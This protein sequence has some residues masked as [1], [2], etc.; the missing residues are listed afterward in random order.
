ML[1]P[2]VAIRFQF[3]RLTLALA[4]IASV[5]LLGTAE[6]QDDTFKS[7]P[8][9][10]QYVEKEIP[11]DLETSEKRAI[12]V[13]NSNAKKLR[14]ADKKAAQASLEGS[15]SESTI[16]PYLDGLILSEMTQTGNETLSELGSLRISFIKD[17]V[18]DTPSGN[19]EQL[20]NT[21]IIPFADKVIADNYHPAV[22]L[23]AVLLIGMIN[24]TDP[25]RGVVARP[26]TTCINYL[27]NLM[28]DA[29]Q[30]EFLKVGAMTGIHR[31]AQ[32]D[33]V[34]NPSRIN[35]GDRGR[36][37]TIAFDIT[38][39][40]FAGQASWKPETS[41]WLRRRSIQILGYLKEPGPGNNR[42]K[43]LFDIV[44]DNVEKLWIR[45]DALMA[46]HQMNLAQVDADQLLEK[47]T[48]FLVD[49]LRLEARKMEIDLNE[50]VAINLL[51]GSVDLLGSEQ[52][53]GG[54][55]GGGRGGGGRGGV[56]LRSGGGDDGRGGGGGG[57]RGGGGRGGATEFGR[58]ITVIDLPIYRT[59]DARRYIQGLA[60]NVVTILTDLES[61]V[62]DEKKNLLSEL[63]KDMNELIEDA[64][65]GLIDLENPPEPVVPV[66]G[67]P[68]QGIADQMI[69]LFNGRAKQMEDLVKGTPSNLPGGSG[70]PGQ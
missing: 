10:E 28:N 49:A 56:D 68:P 22:K 59:N 43:A 57:G 24:D 70:L 52:A 15:F 12:R 2:R 8:I 6:A 62:S 61:K 7:D 48:L 25:S 39:K 38:N 20:L 31:I 16:K 26:S 60:A 21:V 46:L 9:L 66:K 14:A 30:P 36:I 32:F 44:N 51:Y 65:V 42:A 1:A 18:D 58:G 50:L 4:L 17:Y 19:R 3:T 40:A 47:S 5:T 29:N 54:G 63:I 64:N 53:G 27:V 45:Y 67:V 23:N 33:S 37:G 55:R 69:S 35:S 41:Y 13:E 11:D 34:A